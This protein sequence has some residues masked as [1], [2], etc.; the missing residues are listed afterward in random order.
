MSLS[1]FFIYF[2]NKYWE[3]RDLF[4]VNRDDC[5]MLLIL[6]FILFLMFSFISFGLPRIT[7]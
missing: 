4:S 3:M 7:P 5:W 2:Y 6:V 1:K